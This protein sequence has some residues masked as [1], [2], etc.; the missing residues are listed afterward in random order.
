V[1]CE[2]PF[3]LHRQQPEKN[4]QNI[5]VASPDE[6]VRTSM[7]LTYSAG[8]LIYCSVRNTSIRS[9]VV[10][11]VAR[12]GGDE[13]NFPLIPEVAPKIFKL[14]KPKKYF[15]AN[16]RNCLRNLSYFSLQSNLIKAAWIPNCPW[17]IN[18]CVGPMGV[19]RI[20]SRGAVVD[21]SSESQIFFHGKP[22]MLRFHFSHSK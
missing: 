18:R 14:S 5:D 21:F 8:E 3:A 1:F 16:Q 7:A 19:R 10:R 20:F 4:K 17:L 12:G 13:G 15:S 2:R 6:F 11:R 9:V 22:K